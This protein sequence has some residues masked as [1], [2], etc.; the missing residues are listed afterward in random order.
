MDRSSTQSTASSLNT[1]SILRSYFVRG[2]LVENE[3]YC[4]KERVWIAY[5]KLLGE[6]TSLRADSGADSELAVK[7]LAQSAF[8]VNE[9]MREL[10]ESKKKARRLEKDLRERDRTMVLVDMEKDAATH[11]R[12]QL[13]EEHASLAKL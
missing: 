1:I 8:E 7:T 9:L 11:A 10:E 5:L 6:V 3:L 12:C 4:Q 13:D 2:A